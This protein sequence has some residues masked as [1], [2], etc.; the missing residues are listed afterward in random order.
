MRV[1]RVVSIAVVTGLL[2]L[3]AAACV[4]VVGGQATLAA[5]ATKPTA[6]ASG[7]DT[8]TA[9]P[10]VD[11]SP[12]DP[13]SPTVDPVKTKEQVTCVLI[14]ATVKTTNDKFNAAKSRDAQIGILRSGVNGVQGGLSRSGL[15]R[16]DRIFILGN[17]ILTELRRLVTSANRGAS[18]STTPYNNATNKFRTACLSL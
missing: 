5:D 3:G 18:P 7:T 11:P 15:P 17:G 16:N 8:P 1:I 12:T 6:T 10:T 9:S 14:Q 13:P 4:S 2:G